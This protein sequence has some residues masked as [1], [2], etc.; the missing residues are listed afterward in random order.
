MNLHVQVQNKLS[1]KELLCVVLENR[2]VL[3]DKVAVQCYL[4]IL[5]VRNSNW[6]K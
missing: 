5:S 6:T 1:T 3:I 4:P 2:L